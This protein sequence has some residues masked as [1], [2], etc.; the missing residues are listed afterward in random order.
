MTDTVADFF[1]R[2]RNGYQAG[3][4]EMVMPG[5]KF[6]E[7]LGKV[8]VE[9]GFLEEVKVEKEKGKSRLKVRLKYESK[10]PA[11]TRIVMISKPGRR[12][13]TK[14]RKMLVV[15]GGRGVTIVSTAKGVMEDKEACELKLGGEVIGQVW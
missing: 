5:S 8:L 12:V 1:T 4:R 6:K 10:R 15:R 14:M 9:K 13:Y 7:A 11:I 2:I 3:L